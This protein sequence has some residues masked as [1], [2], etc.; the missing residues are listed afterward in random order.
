M[1]AQTIKKIL[2]W[3]IL[4]FLVV[5][6][7]RFAYELYDY[8]YYSSSSPEPYYYEPYNYEESYI[9]ESSSGFSL[10]PL[11]LATARQYIAGNGGVEVN[12]D[13]KYE[14]ISSMSAYSTAFDSDVALLRQTIDAHSG[15][16][17]TEHT[18]GLDGNRSLMVSVGIPPS[19][20]DD[21]VESVKGI[22][23]ITSFSVDKIDRTAD[24]TALLAQQEAMEKTL[25]SYKSL[26][27]QN[28]GMGDMI[29]LEEKIIECEQGILQLKVS[30][31]LFD[32]KQSMCTVEYR[33]SETR[34]AAAGSGKL[35]L[36]FE[37]VIY[38]A[39]NA[40]GWAVLFY[41][42]ALAILLV[43]GFSAICFAFLWGRITQKS[44]P[45]P[46]PAAPPA[47][48]DSTPVEPAAPNQE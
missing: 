46:R 48:I 31:G 27:E 21:L 35:V 9:Y 47:P 30:L 43:T 3:L 38:A 17:Q 44:E 6:L 25:E 5:F 29:A 11:N 45:A 14:M 40:L 24:F 20:F 22:G 8:S 7:L 1:K 34:E 41:L 18:S 26:K 42:A 2:I 23:T 39:E 28:A 36:T 16:V 15:I 4:G 10:K 32:E 33:L 19:R 13:Q 37:M 12:Y